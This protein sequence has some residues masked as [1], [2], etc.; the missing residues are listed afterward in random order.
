MQQM[1]NI[2]DEEDQTF[3]QNGIIV[4]PKYDISEDER[5]GRKLKHYVNKYQMSWIPS[6]ITEYLFYDD[7]GCLIINEEQVKS[8]YIEFTSIM[9]NV[10]KNICKKYEE[11][12]KTIIMDTDLNHIDFPLLCEQIKVDGLATFLNEELQNKLNLKDFDNF[13]NP[14]I[15]EKTDEMNPKEEMKEYEK[16]EKEQIQSA[17]EATS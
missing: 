3:Q 13:E 4:E 11:I 8:L 10:H 2:I 5:K 7:A 17:T 14:D 16:K 1:Q 6:N 12:I 9:R 15:D